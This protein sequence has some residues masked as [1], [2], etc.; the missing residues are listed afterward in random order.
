MRRSAPRGDDAVATVGD[1]RPITRA[2]LEEHVKPKLIEID[3]ER[4][5][6]LK[7]R[8]RRDGRRGA[9]QA[10]GEGARQSRPRQLERT[11]VTAR[12]PSPTDADIQ[13]VYDENKD[14]AQGQTLDQ[15]KPRIVE[16]LKQQKAESGARRSSTS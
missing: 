16:Y 15:V 14:A 3:N 1:A 9:D 11:E 8:A 2:E 6:A 10:G 12:S 5:E 4:Y 7:R 13:K